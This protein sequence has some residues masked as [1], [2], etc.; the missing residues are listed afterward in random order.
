MR[1]LSL[2]GQPVPMSQ[3]LGGLVAGFRSPESLGGPG[4][5]VG[6]GEWRPPSA[7]YGPV[8]VVG[9]RGAHVRPRGC[10]EGVS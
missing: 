5:R 10:V 1:L 3:V 9:T 7:A 6:W 8:A 4:R 2:P